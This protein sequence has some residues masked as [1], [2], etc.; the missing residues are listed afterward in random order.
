MQ[1]LA[2][3]NSLCI[4]SPP[5]LNHIITN[6]QQLPRN[7]FWFSTH[8][9]RWLSICTMSHTAR[10]MFAFTLTPLLLMPQWNKGQT[11][12]EPQNT[13]WT[14][15]LFVAWSSG[16]VSIQ[17]WWMR[18]YEGQHYLCQV[19]LLRIPNKTLELCGCNLKISC[20]MC[21]RAIQHWWCNCKLGTQIPMWIN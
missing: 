14:A 2:L 21:E 10:T 7:S 16:V 4:I 18:E 17:Y 8:N 13:S 11:D 5:N 1:S 3:Q 9:D 6:T 12:G 19:Y 15:A 20:W